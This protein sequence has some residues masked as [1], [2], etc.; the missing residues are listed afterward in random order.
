MIIIYIFVI[1]LIDDSKISIYR[2]TNI[3]IDIKQ[4][5]L[6]NYLKFFSSFIYIVE[7]KIAIHENQNI[8]EQIFICQIQYS[9]IIDYQ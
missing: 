4:A 8:E 1:Y 5:H 3:K 9:Y 6:R 7:F 2:L